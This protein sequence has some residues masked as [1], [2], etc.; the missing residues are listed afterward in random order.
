MR[1]YSTTLK[2]GSGEPAISGSL[3]RTRTIEGSLVSDFRKYRYFFLLILPG[4]LYFVIFRY[5]P[6]V[7]LVI[8]FKDYKITR[9]FFGS[10]WVGLKHFIDFFSSRTSAQLIRNTLLLNLYTFIFGFPVPI[11]FA[12]FLSEL[13]SNSYR[14]S[15]QTMSYLPYF[16]SNVIVVGI[17]FLMLD[18]NSG[19]FNILREKLFNASKIN[20]LAE[21]KY[22]RTIYVVTSIWKSFGWSAVIYLAAIV[23]INPELYEAATIDGATR[24][25]RIWFITIPS[26]RGTITTLLILNL[27][28][29]MTV[30][31]EMVYLLYNPLTYSVSDVIATYVYRKGILSVSG[32]PKFSY[33]TAVGFFQSVVNMVFLVGANKLSKKIQ[34]YGILG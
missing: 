15:L 7:G 4:L 29:M 3:S 21:P 10:E 27:G 33:A 19:V 26:I 34:G 31:F 9:G 30:G 1:H 5:I 16:I 20:F 24:F 11:I 18:Y 6:M 23:G 14:K 8:A 32:L 28:Q 17:V 25:Q 13:K 2:S 12:I 22:F